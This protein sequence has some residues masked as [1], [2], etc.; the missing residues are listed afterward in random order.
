MRVA[1]DLLL[2]TGLRREDLI[3][4]KISDQKGQHL[5]VPTGKSR[6]RNRVLLPITPP[7]ENLLDEISQKRSRLPK[8]PETILFSSR[9]ESWTADGFGASFNRHRKLIGFGPDNN[10][11]TI[12]DMRKTCATNLF[13]L[14][15]RYPAQITDHVFVDMFGWTE[16]TL[17]QMKRIYVSD[18]AVIKA[19]SNS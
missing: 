4:L 8:Q 6:G 3:K 10:G 7:L 12:H 19:M 5:V 13:V 9:G 14:Q 17:S 1:F 18:D 11:P 15:R 16:K 2:Q